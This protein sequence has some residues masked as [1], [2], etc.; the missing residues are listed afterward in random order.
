M[1]NDERTAVE[2]NWQYE[3]HE[4]PDRLLS[5]GFYGLEVEFGDDGKFYASAFSYV[6]GTMTSPPDIDFMFEE[7]FDT[8]EE[9]IIA[10]ETFDRQR[11]E[12]EAALQKILDEMPDVDEDETY[13]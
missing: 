3:W 11:L 9:A 7:T 2:S 1:T 8:A 4:E 12:A 5:E 13:F 10:L 6:A